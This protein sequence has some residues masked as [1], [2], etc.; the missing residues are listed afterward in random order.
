MILRNQ[1]R[2]QRLSFCCYLWEYLFV[3]L[4]LKLSKTENTMSQDGGSTMSQCPANKSS[5]HKVSLA[6]GRKWRE[7]NVSKSCKKNLKTQSH[8]CSRAK[9]VAQAQE[10]QT[11]VRKLGK[12]EQPGAA[13]ERENKNIRS[14]NL[15]KSALALYFVFQVSSLTRDDLGVGWGG[16][17][18]VSRWTW[19][20]SLA[21][22]GLYS[23]SLV[24]V[25]VCVSVFVFVF[26]PFLLSSSLS[27]FGSLFRFSWLCRCGCSCICLCFVSLSH[28][29]VIVIDWMY[30][31]YS[32]S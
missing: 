20:G 24:F 4:T 22:T 16:G 30:Q 21:S 29:L 25:F 23:H 17:W 12:V 9:M 32:W 8:S 26:L 19:D 14:I 27:V 18:R 7:H 3:S 10:E 13:H 28:M 2:R 15:T 5:K 6:A 31:S 1:T 11:I